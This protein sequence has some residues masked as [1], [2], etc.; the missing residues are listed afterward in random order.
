[1]AKTWSA[2]NP[3]AALMARK[4]AVIVDAA[5]KA[6]LDAG[7]AEASVNQIAATAGVSIKTLYRH[8]ESKDELFSA[9]M[10]AACGKVPGA[11]IPKD[12][13]PP[14][15]WYDA[16][17]ADALP[18]AGEE[19]LRHVL[20][21]DQLALYRVVTRDAH[22]FPELGRRYHQA[23]TGT[24]DAKF[25]GYLDLWAKRERWSVRDKRAAAQVFAGLLK[26]R[27]FDEV[28]LGLRQPSN[29]EIARKAREAAKS[30]LLLL[31]D[32]RF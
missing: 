29:A 21:Q 7:Y 15:A 12:D 23:T 32:G 11:D 22:R 6:F 31:N 10:Q 24:R 26:A 4:R 16:P 5:L 13:E 17:P 8:F 3:K 20:S 25:A 19:Y 30:M 28:L 2:D 14:P 1:M 18:K 27:I 9:V